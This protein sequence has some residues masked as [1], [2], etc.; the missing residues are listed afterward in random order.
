MGVC[1]LGCPMFCFASDFCFQGS[2]IVYVGCF[3][4][5]SDLCIQACNFVC[6]GV[7]FS[8]VIC[9]VYQAVILCV[10]L[11]LCFLQ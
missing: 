8:S 9:V 1:F 3:V 4:F 2:K 5:F 10:L 7:V 6:V 11:V